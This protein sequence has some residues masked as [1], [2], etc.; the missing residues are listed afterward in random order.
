[1][2]TVLKVSDA[3]LQGA[4][5][6]EAAIP[7]CA[8]RELWRLRMRPGNRETALHTTGNAR[9]DCYVGE[10]IQSLPMR[11]QLQFIFRGAEKK[12]RNTNR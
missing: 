8:A 3:S 1:M 12:S 7:N 4:A 5:V 10:I 6:V 2:S 9:G 11:T